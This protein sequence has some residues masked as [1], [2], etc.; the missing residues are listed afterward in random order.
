MKC[1]LEKNFLKVNEKQARC[2]FVNFEEVLP[3]TTINSKHIRYF[4]SQLKFSEKVWLS[5]FENR[6]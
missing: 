3:H 2:H 6:E 4:D 5:K 1:F